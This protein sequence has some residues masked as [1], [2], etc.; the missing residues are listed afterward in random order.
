MLGDS[1]FEVGCRIGIVSCPEY[2]MRTQITPSDM[3]R[4]GEITVRLA[5]TNNDIFILDMESYLSVINELDM[6]ID[7]ASSIKNKELRL[8]YQPIYSYGPDRITSFEALLRWKSKK[9]GMCRLVYLYHWQKSA[10]L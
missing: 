5:K 7:L 4:Y 6:E 9:H 10:A 2:Q 3:L 8:N 1:S